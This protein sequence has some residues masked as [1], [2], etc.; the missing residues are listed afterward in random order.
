MESTVIK[1]LRCSIL[2]NA[3]YG[4]C[5]NGGISSRVKNVILVGEGIPEI[6]HASDDY[7]AVVIDSVRIGAKTHFFAVPK[8]LHDQK[9]VWTMASAAFIWSSDSRF[10]FEYPISLHDRVE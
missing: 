1:G 5:S 9:N 10:P 4:D 2:L 8:E 7:P 3:T 6:A